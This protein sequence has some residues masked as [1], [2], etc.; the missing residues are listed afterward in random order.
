MFARCWINSFQPHRKSIFEGA[1]A[2]RIDPMQALR[3]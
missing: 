2:T 1:S 3:D